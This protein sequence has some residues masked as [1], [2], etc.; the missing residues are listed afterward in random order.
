MERLL[1]T[2]LALAEEVESDSL[3]A[4]FAEREKL[5]L[6]LHDRRLTDEDQA[7]LD[8]V[9][10]AEQIVLKNLGLERARIVHDLERHSTSRRASTAYRSAGVSGL[11]LDATR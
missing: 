5:L 6:S 9:R 4:L 10:A 7:I 1:V 11:M 8:K 3:T 2:T